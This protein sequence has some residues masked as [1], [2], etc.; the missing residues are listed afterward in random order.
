MKWSASWR[1]FYKRLIYCAV[2]I[3]GYTQNQCIVLLYCFLHFEGFS[4]VKKYKSFYHFLENFQVCVILTSYLANSR[5]ILSSDPNINEMY[6]L[7]RF[8]E[9]HCSLNRQS[10]CKL[11]LIAAALFYSSETDTFRKYLLKLLFVISHKY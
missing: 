4:S 2:V 10:E 11:L 3:F 1:Q 8:I 9:K 6:I 7:T 5:Y